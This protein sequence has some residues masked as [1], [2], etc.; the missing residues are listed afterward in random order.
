MKN[1]AKN[2]NKV[3]DDNSRPETGLSY[4]IARIIKEVFARN[5]EV[6]TFYLFL[7]VVNGRL[8]VAS[9]HF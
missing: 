5:V 6:P 3:I 8:T 7:H 4:L 1:H 9:T 2:R